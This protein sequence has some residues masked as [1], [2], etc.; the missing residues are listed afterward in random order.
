MNALFTKLHRALV[1]DKELNIGV[2]FPRRPSK[3]LGLG[4]V[5]RLHGTRL[6]LERLQASNWMQGMSG[7]VQ[8]RGPVPVPA[9]H[10]FVSV[11]RVQAK[12]SG[13]ARRR[14][15]IKHFAEKEGVSLDIA[16]TRVSALKPKM[17][18]LPFLQLRSQ[19][20]GQPFRLFIDQQPVEGEPEGGGFNRY[21]LSQTATLPMF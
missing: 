7:H 19:S 9:E 21:G 13:G 20:T 3:G 17:L 12:S 11:R 1:K 18:D 8:I 16:A 14:R 2:S 5:L 6:D 4:A 15:K 10:G